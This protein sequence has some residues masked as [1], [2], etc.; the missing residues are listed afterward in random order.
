MRAIGVAVVAAA[1]CGSV[2]AAH[3]LLTEDT[4]TQGAGG[5]QL[6][7]TGER[8]RDDDIAP[9][10][11]RVIRP[12]AVLSYGV[13]DNADLQLGAAQLRLTLDDGV[14]A[15]TDIGLSDVSVD[16]KWRFLEHGPLSLGLKP[17]VT[18]PTGDSDRGLGSGRW[19][20]GA[21]GILSYAPGPLAFHSHAGYRYNNNLL[22]ERRSLWHFSGALVL[23]A[24]EHLKLVADLAYDT[25]PLPRGG[26][27]LVHSVLG[28]IYGA[29][30]DIDFDMGV[31]QGH[32]TM[33]VD[34]TWLVGLT[35]RW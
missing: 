32:G 34:L 12:A 23:Q 7:L 24:A 13:A 22:G 25:N 29:T 5:F 20:A 1:A 19:T 3:P 17:S 8:A 18:I 4:G 10:V 9:G 15:V 27:S 35:V 2:H 33:A 21:L 11:L 26:G 31:K 16:L 6:E 14:N 30:K 28:V